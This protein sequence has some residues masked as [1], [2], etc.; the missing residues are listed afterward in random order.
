MG[1]TSPYTNHRHKNTGGSNICITEETII[2]AQ[3]A[4]MR[5]I[6]PKGVMATNEQGG[7]MLNNQSEPHEYKVDLCLI[8]TSYEL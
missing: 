6:K 1:H 5:H 2:V 7:S 3:Y 4:K 8:K